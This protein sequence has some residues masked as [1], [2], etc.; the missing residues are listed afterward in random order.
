MASVSQQLQSLGLSAA[1][2]HSLSG[3][4][5]AL[6]EDY[7]SILR[8]ISLIAENVDIDSELLDQLRIDFDNLVSSLGSLA[9][10]STVNNNDWSG[11]DLAIANGGTGASDASQARIN[12]GINSAN[13]LA[14]L[15][16][17]LLSVGGLVVTSPTV[18]AAA[19]DTGTPGTIAWDADNL[20]V[21]V[22]TNTWMRTGIATW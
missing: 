21:C 1:D 7:L 8:N 15:V 11:E 20:Y 5:D 12:L 6:I 2:I 3:W 10:K 19:N 16:G 17:Q 13:I 18:P 14:L 4:P 22:A 9:F